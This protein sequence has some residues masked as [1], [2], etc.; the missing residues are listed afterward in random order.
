MVTADGGPRFAITVLDSTT[1]A[2]RNFAP[3]RREEPSEVGDDWKS[4]FHGLAFDGESRIYASEGESGRVRLID[5]TAGKKLRSF[6]LNQGG[7]ADSYTGD[8]AYDSARGR[9]W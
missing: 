4:V 7:Y 8:L 9:C 3:K 2:T 1:G 5:L 6:D